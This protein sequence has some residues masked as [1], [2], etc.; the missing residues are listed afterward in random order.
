MKSVNLL[1][2]CYD[3]STTANINSLTISA[4]VSTEIE[5][6]MTESKSLN[7]DE[8]VHFILFIF[9]PRNIIQFVRHETS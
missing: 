2:V 9:R 5:S 7:R 4:Y 6:H 8:T 1:I 3:D